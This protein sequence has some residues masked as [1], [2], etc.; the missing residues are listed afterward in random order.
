MLRNTPFVAA[1]NN[2]IKPFSGKKF[3]IQLN[4]SLWMFCPINYINSI[5]PFSLSL[6]LIHCHLHAKIFDTLSIEYINYIHRHRQILFTA[7]VLANFSEVAG[8]E[9]TTAW[10]WMNLTKWHHSF[11]NLPICTFLYFSIL[12]FFSFSFFWQFFQ[13]CPFFISGKLDLVC[14][15]RLNQHN[16]FLIE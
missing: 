4:E 9:P 14:S 15:E 3:W 2:S 10:L 13:Y 7:L 8:F 6:S 11:V 16:T 1:N 12:S 5:T